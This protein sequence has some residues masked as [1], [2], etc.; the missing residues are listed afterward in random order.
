MV[1]GVGAVDVNAH[2]RMDLALVLI[3]EVDEVFGAM[4]GCSLQHCAE[5]DCAS[6]IVHRASKSGCRHTK[7]KNS[8]GCASKQANKRG[9]SAFHLYSVGE[10]G[11][12]N[13]QRA[14]GECELWSTLPGGCLSLRISMVS[15]GEACLGYRFPE[16]E[17]LL[18]PWRRASDT[19]RTRR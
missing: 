1:L 11:G 19:G 4:C 12:D 17:D 16:D 2:A 9:S 5:K 18:L 8:L 10:P 13:A 7:R 15:R 6:W 3:S 14:E